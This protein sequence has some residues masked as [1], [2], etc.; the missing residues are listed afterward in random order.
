MSAAPEQQDCQGYHGQSISPQRSIWRVRPTASSIT[1][2]K[3]NSHPARRSSQARTTCRH[4][5]DG[6][7]SLRPAR[8]DFD[9]G[10]PCFWY[11]QAR[12]Q[13][14]NVPISDARIVRI[15][16]EP[17]PGGWSDQHH[18]LEVLFAQA[19]RQ[20]AARPLH[21]ATDQVCL[22]A[23]AVCDCIRVVHGNQ[24]GVDIIHAAKQPLCFL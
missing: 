7:R 19:D 13:N 16:F 1:A 6:R 8:P 2:R 11:H 3:N 15:P 5:G 22:A 17:G 24:G 14:R 18:L 9:V 10:T 4:A 20:V 21:D 23:Q 12:R